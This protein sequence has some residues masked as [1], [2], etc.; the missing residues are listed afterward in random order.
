MG[1]RAYGRS[2]WAMLQQRAVVA[3]CLMAG[4]R[5]MAQSG[6]LVFLPLFYELSPTIVSNRLLNVAKQ[7]R[8]AYT[9][10]WNAHLWDVK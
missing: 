7:V 1:M 3:L 9:P 2:L 6:L 10:S 5:S 8:R 4:L